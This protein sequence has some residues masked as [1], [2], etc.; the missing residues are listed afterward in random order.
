MSE[1]GGSPKPRIE[2]VKEII[3]ECKVER[4]ALIPLVHRIQSEF[5]H[6]PPE[7]IPVVA[8]SLGLFPSQVQAIISFYPQFY[9]SPRGRQIITICR[10]TACHMRGSQ[11]LL[12]LFEER[13]GIGEGETTADLEYSLETAA[14]VGACALAPNVIIGNQAYGNVTKEQAAKLIR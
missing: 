6:V 14:C 12:R 10:G 2:R 5:G 8:R 4:W 11:V 3:A 1:A 13:L 7:A 9:L